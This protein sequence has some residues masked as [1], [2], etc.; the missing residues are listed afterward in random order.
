MGPDRCNA[1]HAQFIWRDP[2]SS[3]YFR[4]DVT[5]YRR[6]RIILTV[7][8]LDHQP[9]NCD[10]SNLLAMCQR[11]HLRYDREHHA[12]QRRLNKDKAAGQAALF[13]GG[14]G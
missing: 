14:D 2:E 10:E 13:N 5:G 11:C 7:A 8:H 4:Y 1:P 12:E 6:V 9:E 3:A